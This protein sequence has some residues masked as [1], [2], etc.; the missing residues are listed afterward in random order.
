M[1]CFGNIIYSYDVFAM[2]FLC[3]IMDIV[4]IIY[5]TEQNVKLK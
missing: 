5:D 4:T 2:A 1:F 3:W